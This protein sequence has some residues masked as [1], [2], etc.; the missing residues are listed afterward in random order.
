[1]S[2]VVWNE[3]ASAIVA[4]AKKM[5]VRRTRAKPAM[6]PTAAHRATA[7]ARSTRNDVPWF[8]DRMAAV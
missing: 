1:L 8:T 4:T 3:I 6:A 7:A 5:L 2:T